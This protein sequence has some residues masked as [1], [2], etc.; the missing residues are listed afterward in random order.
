MF[1]LGCARGE[2]RKCTISWRRLGR[3]PG[4]L[5]PAYSVVITPNL[6]PF[7]ASRDS[8][9]LAL[10]MLVPPAPGMVPPTWAVRRPRAMVVAMD[11][12]PPFGFVWGS[13]V[14]GEGQPVPE[15]VEPAPDVAS[16]TLTLNDLGNATMK[17]VE[18]QRDQGQRVVLD[19]D[20]PPPA[21]GTVPSELQGLRLAALRREGEATIARRVQPVTISIRG[22]SL[23]N[24]GSRHMEY[25]VCRFLPR[26]RGLLKV[27][28]LVGLARLAPQA[29]GA[30]VPLRAQGAAEAWR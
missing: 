25:W 15:P 29:G 27:P 4:S 11:T 7:L 5:S 6:V 12:P 14:G 17:K 10:F 21:G 16:A 1:A 2:G 18:T 23:R 26:A 9:M 24:R 20:E 8:A 19:A 30:A 28:C 13:A 3:G 22:C